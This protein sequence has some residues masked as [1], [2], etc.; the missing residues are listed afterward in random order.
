MEKVRQN[1]HISKR[2]KKPEPKQY[3]NKFKNNDD[4]DEESLDWKP[5]KSKRKSSFAIRRIIV[6]FQVNCLA[7]M[8]FD[9]S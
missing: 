1:F 2:T 8:F 3:S 5:I 9:T 7:Y 6:N 4:D